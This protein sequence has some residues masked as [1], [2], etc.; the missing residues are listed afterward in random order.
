[1]LI[2]AFLGGRVETL[3]LLHFRLLG[4]L[5]LLT[6]TS[7]VAATCSFSL[8]WQTC[9]S[10]QVSDDEQRQKKKK[11]NSSLAMSAHVGFEHLPDKLV[12]RSI[13]Q[14]SVLISCVGKTGIGKAMLMDTLCNTNSENHESSHFYAC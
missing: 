10:S 11:K 7:E 14:A 1:M 2:L 6:L 3:A 13:Q 9:V 5:P 4:Q 12:N 8:P